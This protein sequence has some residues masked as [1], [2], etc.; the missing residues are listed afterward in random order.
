MLLQ[1]GYT[2]ENLSFLTIAVFFVALLYST[3]GHAGASGYIAVMTLLGLTSPVI[4]PTALILNILV[5]SLTSWQF[6][7][8]GYFS[9]SLFWPLALLSVP[10]SFLGGY[11]HFGELDC[12]SAGKSQ[13]YQKFAY[14]S[15][16][17]IDRRLGWWIDRFLLGQSAI[18]A[19]TH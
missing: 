14:H 19:A 1:I 17:S 12:R 18:F 11:V 4:K 7:R 3:V 8:A 15:L 10:M 2:N 13:Q 6:W 9:W 5:A 16:A